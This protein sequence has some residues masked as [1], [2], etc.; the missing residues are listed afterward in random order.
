M[1][2]VINWR[3]HSSDRDAVG[4][5]TVDLLEYFLGNPL[6]A[7]DIADLHGHILEE[8]EMRTASFLVCD[9]GCAERPPQTVQDVSGCLAFAVTI[10][11]RI[12]AYHASAFRQWLVPRQ[13]DAERLHVARPNVIGPTKRVWKSLACCMPR[14]VWSPVRRSANMSI[15]TYG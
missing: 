1:G 14:Y 12:Q 7:T 11:P 3:L 4:D 2:I 13:S 15:D 5:Q 6:L 10:I 8:I 9:R